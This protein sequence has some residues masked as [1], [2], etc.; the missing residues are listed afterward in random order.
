MPIIDPRNDENEEK[1]K[2]FGDLFFKKRQRKGINLY[3][4]SKINERPQLFGCMMVETGE[5]RCRDIRSYPQL[6]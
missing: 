3:E 1:R 5:S 6:C 2:Q 4:S